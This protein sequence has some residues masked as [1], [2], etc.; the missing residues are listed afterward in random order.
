LATEPASAATIKAEYKSPQGKSAHN[1]PN[2]KGALPPR[3]PEPR[4]QCHTLRPRPASQ[5][6][7]SALHNS[8]KPSTNAPTCNRLH[9]GRS[10]ADCTVSQPKPCIDAAARAPQA[11]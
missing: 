2:S 9:T 5:R 8:N 6:G 10:A 7:C 4:A 11:A 3:R 1:T